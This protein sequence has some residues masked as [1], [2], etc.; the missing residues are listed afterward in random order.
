MATS[1]SSSCLKPP[2]WRSYVKDRRCIFPILNF[3]PQSRKHFCTSYKLVQF[4]ARKNHGASPCLGS[5]VDIDGA[6]ASDWVSISDQLLL[7]TSIL[8]TFMAGVVPIRNSNFI[9]RKNALADDLVLESSE[10]FGRYLNMARYSFYVVFA[11]RQVGIFTNW[12]D[13]KL[14]TEGFPNVRFRGYRTVEE[15]QSAFVMNQSRP[16]R[17]IAD[18]APTFNEPSSILIPSTIPTNEQA[19][20]VRTVQANMAWAHVFLLIAIGIIV[21]MVL[22]QI[23]SKF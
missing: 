23:I 15:A 5:L 14:V 10:S 8:L 1:T 20:Q 18:I 6:S 4:S 19:S 3:R 13:V 21:G 9:S 17:C 12:E 7:M 11:G 2:V 22:N 16:A